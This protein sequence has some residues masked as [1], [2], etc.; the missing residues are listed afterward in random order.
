MKKKKPSLLIAG[1]ATL[2]SAIII[3][4]ISYVIMMVT[5]YNVML[6]YGI[7][8]NEYVDSASANYNRMLNNLASNPG[9]LIPML[10]IVLCVIAGIVGFVLIIVGAI[11][12]SKNNKPIVTNNP[13]P[14]YRDF[15]PQDGETIH[16]CPTC[17]AKINE[18]DKFCPNC[19]TQ[20]KN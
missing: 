14:T 19:G 8:P 7:Y 15:M 9:F 2:I 5:T 1:V 16:F 13:T 6:G 11:K 12:A 4:I 18:S 3:G 20:V 10:L 17:G